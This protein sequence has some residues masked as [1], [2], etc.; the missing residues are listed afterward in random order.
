MSELRS[1]GATIRYEV[2]GEGE[3]TIVFVHGHPFDRTMWAQQASHFA[4]QGWRGVLFDLRG[5]GESV[6]TTETAFEFGQFSKDIETLM[7]HLDIDSTVLCGLSMGG[8]IV[9]DCCDR[10]PGRV[11]GVVLAATTPQ[12][13]T[14]LSQTDRL[15]MADRLEREGTG[16]YAEDVLSSMLAPKT[17]SDMPEVA[18]FVLEMMRGSNAT[19]A[20]AA[21]RARADRPSYERTLSDLDVPAL[22]VVGD[23]DAFTSRSDAELMNA[24]IAGSELLWMR[25]VGHMPNLERP[26][27]FNQAMSRLLD[28]VVEREGEQ[29]V[30]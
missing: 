6:G 19:G 12:A 30:A 2:E 17:I 20:A 23:S 11:S 27:E 15:A 4:K 26:T 29:L 10:F 8:Q 25:D 22:V 21:Q 14:I 18:Q 7:D 16:P 24:L 9:M 3:N 1:D 28:R 5:Y 13:E